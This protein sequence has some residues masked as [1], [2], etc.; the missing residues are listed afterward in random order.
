VNVANADEA[1]RDAPVKVLTQRLVAQE[2]KSVASNA[3]FI[4]AR[5]LRNEING[6]RRR[7]PLTQH[8]WRNASRSRRDRRITLHRY[9]SV[10]PEWR[11]AWL[12][13]MKRISVTFVVLAATE[14][15]RRWSRPPTDVHSD[16]IRA[17]ADLVDNLRLEVPD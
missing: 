10:D 12:A 14:G 17:A 7:A 13:R 6:T 2:K 9:F 8:R 16:D 15:P 1:S 3:N 4:D 5:Q 11:A